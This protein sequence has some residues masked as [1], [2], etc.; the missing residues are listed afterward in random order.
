MARSL[1][2]RAQPSAAVP[3]SQLAVYREAIKQTILNHPEGVAREQMWAPL[4]I[5]G[6]DEDQFEALIEALVEQ[7]WIE[8]S[9]EADISVYYP[10]SLRKTNAQ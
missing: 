9:Y 5:A 6:L 1:I 4:R 7:L 2:G 10:C 3:R 8:V